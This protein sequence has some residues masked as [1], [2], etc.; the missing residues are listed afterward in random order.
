MNTDMTEDWPWEVTRDIERNRQNQDILRGEKTWL[1]PLDE[2]GVRG[3]RRKSSKVTPGFMIY[4]DFIDS[5][6]EWN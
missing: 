1:K 2:L 6:T 5:V 3:Q 4:M